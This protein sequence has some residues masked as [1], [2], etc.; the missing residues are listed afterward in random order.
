MQMLWNR[1]AAQEGLEG[2][3]VELKYFTGGD[4]SDKEV[5][6]TWKGEVIDGKSGKL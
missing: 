2:I 5:I 4:R 6:L 1:R 3:N